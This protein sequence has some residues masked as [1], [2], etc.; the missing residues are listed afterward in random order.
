MA[1]VVVLLIH[2]TGTML[3]VSG[4][5]AVC[6]GLGDV[7][8]DRAEAY[9]TLVAV[10]GLITTGSTFVSGSARD[11][12]LCRRGMGGHRASVVGRGGNAGRG[13]GGMRRTRRLQG[14]DRGRSGGVAVRPADPHPR[15]RY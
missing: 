2:N 3:S 4:P 5:R 11:S 9:C 12:E 13:A 1:V 8:E 14:P 15:S 7:N 6:F 10:V